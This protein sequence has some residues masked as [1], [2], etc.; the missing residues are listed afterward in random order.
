[1]SPRWDRG[2]SALEGSPDVDNHQE[3]NRDDTDLCGDIRHSYVGIESL[4]C[5]RQGLDGVV[6]ECGSGRGGGRECL[7]QRVA[8]SPVNECADIQASVDDDDGEYS[9][10]HYVPHRPVILT[11]GLQTINK[12]LV[13]FHVG[14][15]TFGL[16]LSE[17]LRICRSEELIR[18]LERGYVCSR[19]NSY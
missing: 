12:L 14:S 15:P 16:R 8:D 10:Y 3:R 7:I 2:S 13:C 19:N 1:M 6:L 9:R 4:A 11:D 5:V 18:S 17:D